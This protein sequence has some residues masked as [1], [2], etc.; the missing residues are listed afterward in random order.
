MLLMGYGHHSCDHH[1]FCDRRRLFGCGC[2][3]R[4]A[5]SRGHSRAAVR[6]EIAST[7]GAAVGLVFLPQREY[8]SSKRSSTSLP[9]GRPRPRRN[10][11]YVQIAGSLIGM[12]VAAI[13]VAIMWL[14][15]SMIGALV[16]GI[17]GGGGNRPSKQPSPVKSARRP[18]P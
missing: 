18:S 1:L 13:L 10:R 8:P 17:K 6:V 14:L 11:D 7:I 5:I 12:A 9:H 4:G 16:R 2:R 3:R 15:S